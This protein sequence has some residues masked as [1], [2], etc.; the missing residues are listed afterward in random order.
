MLRRVERK[1]RE[2][3]AAF[4]VTPTFSNWVRTRARELEREGRSYDVV[5][6]WGRRRFHIGRVPRGDPYFAI[7][8]SD[9][10]LERSPWAE[11]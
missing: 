10:S 9:G 11:R 7:E 5:L 4:H 8:L 2:L 3:R 6:V 1:L